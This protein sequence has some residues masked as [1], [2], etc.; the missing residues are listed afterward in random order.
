MWLKHLDCSSH[1]CSFVSYSFVVHL[2]HTCELL[3]KRKDSTVLLVC[4]EVLPQRIQADGNNFCLMLLLVL[5]R[6]ACAFLRFD[7]LFREEGFHG[8][9]LLR[10]VPHPLDGMMQSATLCCQWPW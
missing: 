5:S 4:V 8:C 7:F 3:T 10:M 9:F 2:H 6:E 1:I